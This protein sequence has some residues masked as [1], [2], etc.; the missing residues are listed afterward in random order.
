MKM[1]KT[2]E[3]VEAVGLFECSFRVGR[4]LNRA[5]SAWEEGRPVDDVS[6]AFHNFKE[7]YNADPKAKGVCFTDA[8]R[9]LLTF[10][11]TSERRQGKATKIAK[12]IEDEFQNEETK[13]ERPAV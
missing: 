8:R 2:S 1:F 7:M 3:D 11:T 5:A 13:Q 6:A 10:V 9:G 12:I 4:A